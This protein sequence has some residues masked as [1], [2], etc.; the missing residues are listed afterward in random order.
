MQRRAFLGGVAG[1]LAG[2]AGCLAGATG[3]LSEEEYDVGMSSNAFLPGEVE[4][5]AGETLVW[6]NTSS[7]AHTVT[8]VTVPEGADYFASGGFEDR[9]AAVE[10]WQSS[11][12]GDIQP[13]ETYERTFDV[14]GTYDYYCIPHA[15]SGM[16]GKIVVREG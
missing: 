16:D 1:A 4:I 10:G 6:G 7:R 8:A 15:A 13:G 2:T 12:S 9:E 11:L 3:G 5:T 14:P